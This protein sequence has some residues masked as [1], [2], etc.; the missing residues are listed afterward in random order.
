LLDLDLPG[1][2]GLAL[3]RRLRA[4]GFDRPLL[5]VTARADAEAEP[6]ARA[7]G[8]DAFL[9]KPLTGEAL[10]DALAATVPAAA[11]DGKR[12][13]ASAD[14]SQGGGVQVPR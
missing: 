12:A 4:Q 7:A 5:A 9:R 6:L 11:E 3:A 8:F 1:M 10:A 13:P 14:A 2:D